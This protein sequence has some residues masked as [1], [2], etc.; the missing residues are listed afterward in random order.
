M[1]ALSNL[2]VS[3]SKLIN[4]GRKI[5]Q[6]INPWGNLP[7]RFS[8]R[9]LQ[10][11]RAQE[12]TAKKL[13]DS[14][15]IDRAHAI[16]AKIKKDGSKKRQLT[17][18]F[19]GLVASAVERNFGF[20]LHNVQLQ[21]MMI[22]AQGTVAEMQ[23]GE[24]K[25][26][27]TGAIAAMSLLESDTIHVS[28]TNA[29]LATR[30]LE[31][32]APVF[33]RLGIPSAS[34][35]DGNDVQQTRAAYLKEIT[36]GPGYQ[37]GFDYLRDQVF[38]RENR[39]SRLGMRT[40]NAVRGLNLS[41]SLRQLPEHHCA[42]VDE[43]D[44]VMI[45]EAVTPLV[46]SGATREDA[47][48]APFQLAKRLAEEL[49][50][51]E[52]FS[53]ELPEHTI[54][55]RDHAN[56]RCHERVD[57][58]KA[59]TLERPWRVYIRNALRA[60][61][62]LRRD[63]DYVVIDGEIQIVDQNTGRIFPDRTW[64][65]GLHQAVETKEGVTVQS[66]PPSVAQISRQ[67]YLMMY[68]KLAGLTGTAAQVVEEFRSIY[69]LPTVTIP[70]NLPSIRKNHTARFFRDQEAK[71]DA[72]AI[73]VARRQ[74]GGQPILI[75]TRTIEE[76]IQVANRLTAASLNT[77]LLNGVQDQ[78]EADIV[79]TAGQVGKIT[80]A[81][82]MAG[83]GTDI[84][85]S[86]EAIEAGGL[87]VIGYSPNSSARIDRQ[88]IGR[89]ARQGKP[90]SSQFFIAADDKIVHDYGPNLSKQIAKRAA[91]DGETSVDFT[92]QIT[93]LQKQIEASQYANRQAMMRRDV[94][95]DMVRE[96]IERE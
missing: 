28:T 6:H 20:S 39:L 69:K 29:Y 61:H 32:L 82:N 36:Y 95:M 45:D 62:V 74:S 31:E 35:P 78:E 93:G 34:L 33:D 68:D 37:F 86:S 85:L 38:L 80:I 64:Q 89:G 22:G 56:V 66:A 60:L 51:G 7:K 43:A 13:S 44:S 96:S 57:S 55:L 75:G 15:L 47:D 87:H 92:H 58:M 4:G 52:D 91:R 23:T 90:G 67:R 88:L 46:I 1:N 27:V 50:E 12:A 41:L 77:V 14:Q 70:T 76:S 30:D 40:L 42:I 3:T 25:T 10:E 72:I 2:T 63:V 19:G 17:Y 18:E 9:D 49:V 5:T 21:A 83:R 54:E 53:I 24:G 26:V 16:R 71:L 59:L 11:L 48:P 84:K 81:T 65:D 94:W 73:D 8:H 79:A